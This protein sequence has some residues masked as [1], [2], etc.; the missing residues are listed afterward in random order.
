MRSKIVKHANKFGNKGVSYTLKELYTDYKRAKDYV[1]SLKTQKIIPQ[2][3]E[4]N[5]IY[6]H[7][8]KKYPNSFNGVTMWME[9]QTVFADIEKR[10]LLDE[11]WAI[12]KSEGAF[13]D[14]RIIWASVVRTMHTMVVIAKQVQNSMHERVANAL[15]LELLKFCIPRKVPSLSLIHI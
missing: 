3:S 13:S 11:L 2:G 15:L 5:L 1:E 14:S 6:A 12:A 4:P 9:G 10:G 8:Q 7:V